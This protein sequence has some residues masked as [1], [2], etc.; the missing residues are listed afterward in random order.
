MKKLLVVLLALGLIVAFGATA[1]AANLKFSGSYYVTGNYVNDPYLQD[2]TASSSYPSS[3]AYFWQRFRL[4]PVFEIAEGLTFTGRMDAME[5]KWGDTT[6]KGGTSDETS[7]R[8]MNTSNGKVQES[9]EWERAYVTF[10]TKAGRFQVGYQAADEWGTTFGDSGTTRPRIMYTTAVGPMILAAVYEKIYEVDDVAANTRVDADYDTYA[11]FGIFKFKGG[12]AGLLYKYYTDSSA[13]SGIVGGK[14]TQTNLLSPYMKATFGPV[15]VEAELAYMFGKAAKFDVANAATPDVDMKA[16]NAYVKGQFNFGAGNVGMQLG[17]SSGDDSVS[18]DTTFTTFQ[19]G[20]G[21]S[22]N[23]ALLLLNDDLNTQ[24]GGTVTN[25][26]GITNKKLN[27]MIFNLYAGFNPMAK[28]NL[29]ASLTYAQAA[30]KAWRN[31]LGVRTE[32]VGSKLGT[33]FDVTATYKIFDQLTY[34]VGAGYLWTGDYFKG[35]S[36]SATIGN[37]Y[38]VK[39]QLTLNF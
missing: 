23:P 13:S 12:E 20:C 3:R 6:W 4:Q 21:T 8:R 22:W 5:K 29:G 30:H 18:T 2:G 25:P 1:S 36:S 31:A 26:A 32:N 15:Y 11:L 27:V 19:G 38:I 7:S 9:F 24:G 35:T 39:N 10:L 17:Y 14:K 37:S 28:L 16:W 33:E 34:M